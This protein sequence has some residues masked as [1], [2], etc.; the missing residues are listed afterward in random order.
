MTDGN[1]NEDADT[2]GLCD[3]CHIAQPPS[4]NAWGRTWIVYHCNALPLKIK[5]TISSCCLPTKR[6]L[7][8]LCKI[9]MYI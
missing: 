4:E 5:I 7:L 3:V 8:R 9:H 2:N 6:L 1:V